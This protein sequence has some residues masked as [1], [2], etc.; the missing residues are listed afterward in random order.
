MDGNTGIM[1]DDT[2]F[3]ASL[4]YLVKMA[5]EALQEPYIHRCMDECLA[6]IKVPPFSFKTKRLLRDTKDNYQRIK[7]KEE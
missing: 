3:M 1:D 5:P 2:K 4:N 7:R 6:S